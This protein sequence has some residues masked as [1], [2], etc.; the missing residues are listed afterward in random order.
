MGETSEIEALRKALAERDAIIERQRMEYDLLEARFRRLQEEL[1]A[2]VRELEAVQEKR[3][4][5][6]ARAFCPKTESRVAGPEGLPVDEPGPEGKRGRPGRKRGSHNL[7]ADWL[8]SHV[9]ATRVVMPEEYERLKAEGH[10]LVEAGEDV[11]Y[12]VESTPARHVVTKIIRKKYSD[13]TAGSILQALADP[14]DP[15]PHSI[16][17]PSLAAELIGGK[18]VLGLPYYR[19]ESNDFLS[20]VGVSRQ[21]MCRVQSEV[22][23]ALT[24]LYERMRGLL[25]GGEV[26]Y[27]DE[28]TLKVIGSGKSS[29]Y[30][31]VYS[32]GHYSNPV[33]V[34]E[35]CAGRGG[36][37]PRRMLSGFSG[38]LVTD[39]YQGYAGIPGAKNCLCWA[40]ARR[41][42]AEIVKAL[43]ERARGGLQGRGGGEDD[44]RG[45]PEGKGHEG[46]RMGPGPDQG[47]AGIS[48][49]QGPARRRQGLPRGGLARGGREAPVGMRVHAQAVALL[50]Q[51][52]RGRAHR[53][54]QQ[55]I[56]AGRQALRHSEEELPV[57]GERQ[58]GVVHG[59]GLQPR[60]DRQGERDRP[61]EI[62][63]EM[64]RAGGGP[65]A[66]R[67]SG[68]G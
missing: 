49:L 64:H 30:M 6:R 1:E 5:E 45:L 42:F 15:F 47:R 7:N 12:K 39:A 56:G 67:R 68:L 36:E 50:R 2:K 18:M 53:D 33:Y 57:L 34:Y 54:L 52:L 10:V 28:T 61:R 65:E 22:S 35:F 9:S 11:S 3:R 51:V 31:W 41:N 14:G 19:M 26:V 23:D 8:E 37:N 21:T 38:Y 27:A 46:G 29:C 24:P 59:E 55:H 32:S 63:R 4:V 25:L 62:P 13:R 48:R 43:G 20:G 66:W 60:A 40:H 58:G 17:T 44:R 16:F